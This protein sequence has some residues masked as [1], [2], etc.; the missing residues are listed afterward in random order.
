MRFGRVLL[1]K[2]VYASWGRVC[3]LR[4]CR[5]RRLYSLSLNGAVPQMFSLLL[6]TRLGFLGGEGIDGGNGAA[7][8]LYSR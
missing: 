1:C 8:P 2:G 4:R 6:R 3:H 7:T 5:T